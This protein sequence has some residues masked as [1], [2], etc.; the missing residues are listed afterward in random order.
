MRSSASRTSGRLRIRAAQFLFP[1]FGRCLAAHEC[2][3]D[4]RVERVVAVEQAV[5]VL[6][7][8]LVGAA[9]I[10]TDRRFLVA[11]DQ[12]IDEALHEVRS[13]LVVRAAP[14]VHVLDHPHGLAAPHAQLQ[15]VDQQRE[16]VAERPFAIGDRPFDHLRHPG[17]ALQRAG[18]D[19]VDGADLQARAEAGDRRQLYVLLAERGEHVLDVAEEH[20]ARADQQHT[21]RAEP[22]AERVE[23]VRGAVQGHRG[24]AGA[25]SARDDQRAL[26]VGADRFVLF[27]LDGRDDVAHAAG[28]VALERGEQRA[29][30]GDREAGFVDGLLVE[31]LVV[32]ADQ[33]A[34]LLGDEVPAANDRHRLDRG[35]AVEGL[36]YRGPPVDDERRVLLVFHGDPADVPARVIF[37]VEAAEHERRVADV[38]VGEAALG[39]VPG[40]VALEPGLV[41]SA[42]PHVGVR[43]PDPFGRGSHGLEAGVRGIHVRLLGGELR[44]DERSVRHEVSRVSGR[45]Q[46]SR[47]GPWSRPGGIVAIRE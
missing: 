1:P 10:R 17:V 44:V 3:G 19:R 46:F 42:R 21:L 11:R 28:A 15:P 32:E 47:R 18:L 2:A 20:R 41:G 35:R 22:A 8:T 29:F 4:A 24:L 31:H 6:G 16:V 27:G 14:A 26:D 13:Q 43:L 36:R 37:H 45:G 39:H 12:Q 33:L 7:R 40:D 23:E 30:T 38:E 25:R 34:A 5:H 9:V